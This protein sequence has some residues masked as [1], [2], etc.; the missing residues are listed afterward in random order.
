MIP[1]LIGAGLILLA[2]LF[3]PKKLYSEK[4]AA[5]AYRV[6]ECPYAETIKNYS[7]FYGVDPFLV[8]AVISWEQRSTK[9]W[10]KFATNPADPSY[11]LGQVTPYIGVKSGVI[12]D[13]SKY[14]DLYDPEKNIKAVAWFLGYLTEHYSEDDSIQMYNEGEP[15]FKAGKRVPEYLAGVKGMYDELKNR[16]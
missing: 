13:E 4:A 14:M 9:F 3:W 11:G 2:L 16:V 5:P 1:I 8:A 10:N 15:N 6:L 7:G 12:P